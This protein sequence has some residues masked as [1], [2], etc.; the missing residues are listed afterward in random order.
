MNA[1]A[2]TKQDCVCDETHTTVMSKD[3]EAFGCYTPAE[4][5][6]SLKVEGSDQT[7]P[8]HV[9]EHWDGPKKVNVFSER[10]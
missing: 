7:Y 10:K 8:V 3:G 6:C 1:D 2:E 5:G 9:P 4:V